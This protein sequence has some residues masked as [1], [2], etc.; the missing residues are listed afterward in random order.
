MS[1][2]STSDI[3]AAV[4]RARSSD[5]PGEIACSLVFTARTLVADDDHV[6]KVFLA[7]TMLKVAYQLD[8]DVVL[9]SKTQ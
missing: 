6:A 9:T 1:L 4:R 8:P 5:D 2:N 7:R 3:V